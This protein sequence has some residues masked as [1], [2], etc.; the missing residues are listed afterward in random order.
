MTRAPFVSAASV[1]F[2]ALL[3]AQNDPPKPQPSAEQMLAKYHP[4]KGTVKVGG[5]AEVKFGDGWLW[6]DRADGQKFLRDRGNLR[7][8][9]VL[10]V[11]IPPDFA[12]DAT[13][14]VYSYDDE[15]HVHD[16]EQPDYDE[17]LADMKAGAE[18]QTKELKKAGRGGVRLI[19]WAEPPHYDKVQHKLYWAERLHFDEHEGDTL[20]YNVRVLGRSGHLVVNGVGGI[21]QLAQVAA[22]SKTL[23]AATE[24]IEGKRY[25]DFDPAY[26]KVAAYGIGGLIAGKVALKI[27]LFAKLGL[28]LKGLIKPILVGLVIIGGLL[29]RLFRGR[30]QGEQ[31]QP[32]TPA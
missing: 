1:L 20:N 7:D 18:E 13:F 24:F 25:T 14:A 11:A 8:P 26:D 31:E 30:K 19:G 2:A 32:A 16:D 22:H 9:S 21:E 28:L 17:L 5:V 3:T 29:V 12:E 6:L 27:G 10:G 23:L 15:G 4:Q